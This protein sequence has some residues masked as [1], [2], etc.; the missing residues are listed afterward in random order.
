LF[1]P[2]SLKKLAIE[3]VKKSIEAV[4]PDRAVKE[5]L[6]KLNLD[7]VILVAVGKAA[8]RMAKAA[9]EVLGEKI[10]KGVVVTKYGHSEGLIDDFE[11]YEAGHPVPD[12]NTIKATERVLELVD[13]LNENDTV[14]F[15]L[16]GGGSSLFEL[17]AEGVSL[18][19][20]QKLTSALLKSGASIE[21]INTVR[22][23]LSQVKGGRFAERVFP[24]KVVALVLSDVL[25]DRLDVIASGPAWPDSSTSEDALKVLERYGIEISESVKRAILRETPKHL[26]NVEIHLIGNVQKVCDEAKKLAK[27]KGFNA[28]IITTSLDCEAREA[29]RF[30]ASIMKEVK[31]KDRPLKKPAALIFG[32]ETVVHVKGNG[33]GGRN[34]ELALSAAIALE[35][36]EGVILCSAGTDGTDGP[37]DAAGGIVDG[38]TAKTLK[39]MGEDPYQY[40]E[41]N[42]S[43]NALKKSGALLIT[44]PTGTNVNDL[45]IGLIV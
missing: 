39:A 7:R 15:L 26:S 19:E 33:I 4:F 35:G 32:G 14:L 40:L 44:G 28:E 38:S 5:T 25:G 36:I 27:E 2:E 45:I 12:E 23:H 3:I 37:T 13:Q 24:A 17:P 1:D 9:Y 29:G 42:D 11:I 10:R 41:N 21:E 16:S 22:K 6:P 30:I 34:Q 8:W 43:Y 18:E 31:F 20:I